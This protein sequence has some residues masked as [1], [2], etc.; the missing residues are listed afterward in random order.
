MPV[1]EPLFREFVCVVLALQ[2]EPVGLGIFVEPLVS[3][4]WLERKLRAQSLGNLPGDVAFNPQQV[5]HLA[6]VLLTPELFA[7]TNVV[8]FDIDR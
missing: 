8:E 5:T 6:V 4:C 1:V 2:I 7:I 3:F